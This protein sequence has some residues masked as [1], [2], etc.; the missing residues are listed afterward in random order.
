MGKE[1]S[2]FDFEKMEW[3]QKVKYD[4]TKYPC[5]ADPKKDIQEEVKED[6][7]EDEEQPQI[8][9]VQGLI[10]K[11]NLVI[12]KGWIDKTDLV[13]ISL[14]DEKQDI[15]PISN[16]HANKVTLYDIFESD[17]GG[18]EFEEW[19]HRKPACLSFVYPKEKKF[20]E[21]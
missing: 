16:I 13:F 4:W 1:Y 9:T 18:T 19:T 12:S 21:K 8:L 14:S 2:I 11:L 7:Q 6:I 15:F 17:N 5:F 20:D 3:V 10:D